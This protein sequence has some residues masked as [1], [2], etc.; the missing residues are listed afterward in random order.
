MDG[1]VE[2]AAL[3]ALM[4]RVQRGDSQAYEQLLADLMPRV[5]GLVHAQRGFLAAADIDDLVQDVLLSVHA[6]R[7]T[8]DP[9]RPFLPWLAAIAR[10]RLAD[11]ARRHA[12]LVA[13]EFVVDEIDVTFRSPEPN[14]INDEYGDPRALGEAL[15][16]LPAGQRRAIEWLK[17][18]ERSLQETSSATGVSVG[19]LKVATHRA[20]GALRKMLKAD[21]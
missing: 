2:D 8:Y 6:A 4:A 14:L 7:A 19:A 21:E 3:M 11:A 1:V 18:R 13:H 20:M 10:H 5:R 16:A 15:K 9:G 17:L 12:R